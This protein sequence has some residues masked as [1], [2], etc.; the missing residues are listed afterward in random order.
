MCLLLGSLGAKTAL[1]T[2]LL[3]SSRP[4][5]VIVVLSRVEKASNP[6]PSAVPFP[7]GSLADSVNGLYLQNY[8]GQSFAV[9]KLEGANSLLQ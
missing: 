7:L 4:A 5:S 9:P 2:C 6:R 3:P 1:G 8:A